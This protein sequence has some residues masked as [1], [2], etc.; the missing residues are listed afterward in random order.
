M[1][2]VLNK[3]EINSIFENKLDS[4]ALGVFGHSFGGAAAGQACLENS[5]FDGFINMDGAP[6]GDS[7][8]TIIKQPFM[9]IKGDKHINF[10]EA[11]YDPR[12]TNYIDVTINGAKHLDFTDFTVLLPSLKY[13]GALGSTGG[14]LQEIILKDY[15][16]SFFDKYLKGMN[17][18]LLDESIPKY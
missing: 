11:G 10:I 4:S 8:H 16:T 7:V 5:S 13:L 18:P 15:V 6:F 3:D 14:Y 17:A 1:E 9:I 12:Q 2:Y